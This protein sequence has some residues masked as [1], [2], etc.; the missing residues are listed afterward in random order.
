MRIGMEAGTPFYPVI[1]LSSL[2]DVNNDSPD[3]CHGAFGSKRFTDRP[4]RT[5]GKL[6]LDFQ[7]KSLIGV[8]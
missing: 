8:Y 3:L 6:L 7:I 5:T 4:P 1:A 2:Y